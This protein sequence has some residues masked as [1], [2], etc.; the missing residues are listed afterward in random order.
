VL[1]LLKAKGL[2]GVFQQMNAAMP[3]AY[4]EASDIELADDLMMALNFAGI[5]GTFQIT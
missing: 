2:T 5:N 3:D 1:D 4:R